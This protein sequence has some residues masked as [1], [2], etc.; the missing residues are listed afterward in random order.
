VDVP[1]DYRKPRG[2]TIEIAISRLASQDPAKRRGILVTNPGGPGGP[3]LTFPAELKDLGMPQT[4]LDAYDVIGVDP[5][6][7]GQST[8]V[9]CDLNAEQQQQGM[10][11]PWA[12]GPADVA[13]RA[14]EVKVIARQCQTSDTASLL[15]HITTANTAR[16]LDRIREAL[17]EA[18]LSYLGY[19]YGTYLGSVY[20]TLFPQRSD[21][22]VLD[23]NL[24]PDGYSF[25]AA[26]LTGLGVEKRFS[27]FAKWLAA[28]HAEWGMGSNPQQVRAKFFQLADNLRR[29][30]LPG[31]DNS[32]F[33]LLLI[34][35]TRKDSGFPALAEL[36]RTVERGEPYDSGPVVDYD[37][38]VSSHF[39]VACAD[40]KWPESVAVY[41]LAVEIDR[42]RYPILG[43]STAGIRPC[44]YWPS[45]RIEPPV[46]IGDRGPANVL[47][48]QNE[49]D[50][51]TPPV[52]AQQLRK[53]FGH[54]AVMVTADQGGHGGYLQADNTCLNDTVTHYLANGKRPPRDLTCPAYLLP[55]R[56]P[57]VGLRLV[58]DGPEVDCRTRSS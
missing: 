39:H 29:K 52:L 40:S 53:A 41:Q 44:A 8:P 18:K 50:P 24:G 14:A 55:R 48:A 47:L 37:N 57:H 22:I 32:T 2:R 54:R 15:P 9:T 13:K 35:H 10:A 30:P 11:P 49:R 51:S 23:S 5:R 58:E 38:I 36:W 31:L 46:Q 25:E 16:D 56:R 20:T 42:R 19:S 34:A 33:R 12:A 21:R 27:D 43:A 17:G 26:R 28:R 45:H 3:G 1:L 7:V 6:G 4:V